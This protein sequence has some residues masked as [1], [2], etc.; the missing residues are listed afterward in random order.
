MENSNIMESVLMS[1]IFY[2]FRVLLSS[3]YFY[4]VKTIPLCYNYLDD[5][6]KLYKYFY[7]LEK[8]YAV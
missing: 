8:I 4:F 6:L 1:F 5:G 3:V 2:K 7:I